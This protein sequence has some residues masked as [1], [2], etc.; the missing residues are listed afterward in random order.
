MEKSDMKL[1]L[2]K[3]SHFS[4]KVRL[5]LD[6]YS[7]PYEVIDIGNVADSDQLN[8]A[9]NP[10]MSVPVLEDGKHWLIESDHIAV[11][12]SQKLDSNNRYK[13]LTR[14][15]SVLNAR[16]VLNGI[17]SSEV[18]YI[19]AKRTQVP[20]EQ[21]SYF[22]KC[23]KVIDQG[24]AWL[25]SR[26]ELFTPEYISYLDLHLVCVW[27]HLQYYEL[28]DMN[29]FAALKEI[30]SHVSKNSVVAGTAPHILKPK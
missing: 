4:R 14:E 16:A 17:M 1:Y 3:L 19:L 9:G 12:L 8:F 13:I 15:L 11:Y 27:D 10:L 20:V 29:R 5:I 28:L 23:L 24:L 25:E 7:V 26:S 18:K 22:A 21:Y 6:L 30:V 2:T